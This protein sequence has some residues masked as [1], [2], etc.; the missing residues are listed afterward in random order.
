T[1]VQAAIDELV[2]KTDELVDNG[3]GTFTHTA[4]DGTP[5]T[6]DANTTTVTESGGV[7]TFT[8]GAGTTITTI[9][10]NAD[11]IAFDNTVTGLLTATDV[12]AAIDELVQ[13]REG[14][15]VNANR[16]ITPNAVD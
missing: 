16:A 2:Q 11:A 8:D 13:D 15:R 4:V 5:V 9:D 14:P 1:D 6:F 3:D 10:T 12:Q 7:Y